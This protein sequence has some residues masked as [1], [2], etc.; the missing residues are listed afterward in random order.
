[1]KR[2]NIIIVIATIFITSTFHTRA[3]IPEIAKSTLS[4]SAAAL[5]E[6]GDVPVSMFTGI[7]KVEIPLY[8]LKTGSHVLPIS[9]SYHGGGVKLE[10]MS[11]WTGMGWSLQAGGCITRIVKDLPDEY[12]N[13]S[14][15]Y[16]IG[17]LYNGSNYA[18]L[19]L[20]TTNQLILF[21]E[22]Q[23]YY[24]DTEPDEF[25][26]NFLNYHGKFY[27]D[28]DMQW[29]VQCDKA[30]EIVMN[31]TIYPF[32]GML[33]SAIPAYE[34]LH[35]P[36]HTSAIKGFTII[37]ED[38][39]RYI[40]G[41]TN[42]AIEYSVDFF[43]QCRS[44]YWATAWQ[45]TRIAY[46]DGR[47]VF[48]GY[49]EHDEDG[50]TTFEAQF[51]RSCYHWSGTAFWS[52]GY[53]VPYNMST[54]TVVCYSGQLIKP[55]YLAY[56]ESDLEC[57]Q[58]GR[59]CYRNMYYD[60][61]EL[62]RPIVRKGHPAQMGNPS[63]EDFFPLLY[64]NSVKND[65]KNGIRPR[66]ED[67]DKDEFYYSALQVY[68]LS[69]IEVRRRS[70]NQRLRLFSLEYNPSQNQRLTLERVT[71]YGATANDKGREYSFEYY[72]P[73]GL[74]HFLAGQT[75]H[76]GFY[77]GDYASFLNIMAHASDFAQH[78]EPTED[79]QKALMGTLKR[80]NYPTGGFTEFEYE[81]HDYRRKV[82]MTH[83]GFDNLYS[84]TKAGGLRVRR[85]ISKTDENA[86]SVVKEYRYVRGYAPGMDNLPSSGVLAT[87]HQ[88]YFPNYQPTSLVPGN[89]LC[90]VFSSQ[91]MVAGTENAAGCHVGYSEVAEVLSDG[92]YTINRFSN[93]D[94]GFT[95]APADV[96]TQPQHHACE[97]F[98]S[99]AFM[100]GLL[101][102]VE[103][104]RIDGGTPQLASRHSI[105]YQ[106]DGDTALHYVRSIK[107]VG[108]CSYTQN[109]FFEH[110]I[111]YKFLEG[112]VYRHY[113]FSPRK[114]SET[115]TRY[116][117]ETVPMTRTTDY[118]YFDY[119]KLPAAVITDISGGARR[120]T[121]FVYPCDSIEPQLFAT[122]TLSPIVTCVTE[123]I[124]GG[125]TTRLNCRHNVYGGTLPMPTASYS[126]I[127][128]NPPECR[129]CYAYDR[130]GNPC[131]EVRDSIDR[132]IY[133]WGYKG[134]Y[135]VAMI[136]GATLNQVSDIIGDIDT[137]SALPTPDFERIHSLRTALPQAQV[138]TYRYLPL[139]GL[140]MVTQPN[141]LSSYFEYDGLG[142]LTGGRDHEGNY[143]DVYN[144]H[145]SPREQ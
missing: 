84:N 69:D 67:I 133:L 76:W 64:V 110:Y 6:Y 94:N 131:S 142:R 50:F 57:I 132:T 128:D 113:Y 45:L 5:S 117:Q 58:F 96:I 42:K 44:R 127:G 62:L 121:S 119:N 35:A 19:G 90:S 122:H 61:N 92:A 66:P 40:F 55:S 125:A 47:N 124:E 68:K 23:S 100:R 120:R 137:F 43:N 41:G 101:L 22:T 29:K 118:S 16:S 97:P 108:H 134:Q 139:V 123:H 14:D 32:E 63:S 83:D 141:G 105:S 86:D 129:V 103:E 27:L 70:D 80:V 145:Y 60:T 37:A 49:E 78:R 39:T 107:L 54:D 126:A 48:F 130:Y 65:D 81:Q 21:A 1:M 82:R 102:S 3:Q 26:F 99:K 75:D 115:L 72:N 12:H 77:N 88:Y 13:A 136:R 116:E 144:Y 24:H 74:P 143:I 33:H 17:L 89:F 38:G 91:S 140:M 46:T 31:D 98:S 30:V 87:N 59:E 112:A 2:K 9:L 56:I 10:Q 79:L 106:A 85:I 93:I 114:V 20:N 51:G 11:G 53:E 138:T 7:P 25:S 109:E 18:G 4:P 111:A 52:G 95:D 8:E 104:Y 34:S 36:G 15:S 73:A 135:L 28:T 71:E